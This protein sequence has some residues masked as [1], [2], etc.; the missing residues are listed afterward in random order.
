MSDYIPDPFKNFTPRANPPRAAQSAQEIDAAPFTPGLTD[1]QLKTMAREKLSE[2]LQGIDARTSPSL[3][4]SVAREVMD[5]IEG[6]PTQRI[7]QSVDHRNTVV[8]SELSND[9]LMRLVQ[10]MDKAGALPPGVK[11]LDN[12]RVDIT[13]ASYT[14]S[15]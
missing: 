6:K 12:G 9:E 4:L 13:D 5:R 2:L 7:E 10:G 1:D 15:Q 8:V 3:L 11:L 14:E